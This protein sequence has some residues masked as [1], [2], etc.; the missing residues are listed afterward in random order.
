MMHREVVRWAVLV[1]IAVLGVVAPRYCAYF[2]GDVAVDRWVQPSIDGDLAWARTLSGTADVPRI[3]VLAGLVLVASWVLAGWRGA[4]LSIASFVGMYALGQW[5]GPATARA[6]PSPELPGSSF[7]SLFA[8][9]WASTF[10]FVAITIAARSSRAVRI[11]A[12]TA[13]AVLLAVGAVARIALHAHWLSD[14]LISYYLGLLWA[15]LLVRL[16]LWRSRAARHAGAME[17]SGWERA[18]GDR[19]ALAGAAGAEGPPGR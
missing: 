2:P 16:G 5:L 11:T 17:S 13:C 14:L 9:R 8:L 12:L 15:A 10:G 1:A 18:Q 3:L 19:G 7:P 4:L 6:R